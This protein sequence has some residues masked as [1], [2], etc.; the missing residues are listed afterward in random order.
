MKN[1][2]KV[3]FPVYRRNNPHFL[4]YVKDVY[5]LREVDG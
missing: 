2:L 3:E 4:D 5:I 1:A